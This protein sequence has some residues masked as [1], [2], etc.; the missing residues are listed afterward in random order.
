VRLTDDD[1]AR[2]D[3]TRVAQGYGRWHVLEARR[4]LGLADDQLW[5][6][7]RDGRLIAYRVTTRR[8]WNWRLSPAA[9]PSAGPR[10][11]TSQTR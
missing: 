4:A 9:A 1:I 10:P 3:G 2:L 8:R 11:M 5:Q 7:L 6:Q